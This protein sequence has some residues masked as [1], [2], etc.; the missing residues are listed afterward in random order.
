M[1]NLKSFVAI[2]PL[3]ALLLMLMAMSTVTQAQTQTCSSQLSNL[4][5]CI[6]SVVPGSNVSPST[7]CCSAI[8]QVEHDCICT[9]LRVVAQMPTACKLPALTCSP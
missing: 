9:T 6:P 4:N 5:S 1:A 7:E 2:Y 8:Q 3:A